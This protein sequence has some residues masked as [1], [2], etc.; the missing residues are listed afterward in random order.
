MFFQKIKKSIEFGMSLGIDKKRCYNNYIEMAKRIGRPDGIEVV[1][2][3][4]PS[5]D[6][7]KIVKEFAERNVH[8]ICDKP[9]TASLKDAVALEKIVKKLKYFLHL[10]II[11]RLIQC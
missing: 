11:T 10:L 3:M 6:H 7:Y 9:L 5:G 4:T 8:V 2:I 1:G